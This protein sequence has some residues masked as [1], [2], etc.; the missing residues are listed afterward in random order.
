MTEPPQDKPFDR[1][2]RL[3]RGLG[4]LISTPADVAKVPAADSGERLR[5]IPLNLISPNPSQPRREFREEE[6]KELEDSLRTNGLL[7]PVTVR[8]APSGQGYELI[9]G[10]RRVRAAKRVGW[11]AIPAVVRPISDAQLLTLALVENLQREDLNPIEEA[12]G[13]RRLASEFGLSQQQV[14]EAVGKDRSTVANVL[15]LLNLPA[16]VQALVA[17]GQL[18]AGHARALLS[19]PTTA[20]IVDVARRIL[21]EQLTVRDVERLGREEKPVRTPIRAG[22]AE[23]TV[24]PEVRMITDRLRRYLQTDVQI[25]ENGNARGEVRMRFYSADDLERLVALIAGRSHDDAS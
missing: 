22:S 21:S 16:E 8:P 17:S 5:E 13:Y 24:A 11:S 4:A 7:Q 3:G 23:K 15:R 10:E 12:E 20:S 14:A 19:L 2:R 1:N 18:S 9:A 6:L 25:V